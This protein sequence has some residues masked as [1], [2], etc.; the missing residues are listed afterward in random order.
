[1][2]TKNINVV[3]LKCRVVEGSSELVYKGQLNINFQS[4]DIV[5][6]IISGINC[7]LI[8]TLGDTE[9]GRVEFIKNASLTYVLS[10]MLTAIQTITLD[11][12][13]PVAAPVAQT[14]IDISPVDSAILSVDSTN[15]WVL[16]DNYI[17]FYNKFL[18]SYESIN[19]SLRW[20]F[21]NIVFDP[22]PPVTS[23]I[24]SFPQK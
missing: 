1:M 2:T 10:Q 6:H 17:N 7:N 21:S 12:G 4:I 11:I 20:L 5:Q 14:T 3:T 16:S 22:V 15:F 24:D 9:V 13:D 8:L 18:Q 19:N 23:K